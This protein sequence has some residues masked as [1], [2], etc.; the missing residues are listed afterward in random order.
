MARA[1][2]GGKLIADHFWYGPV[3]ETGLRRFAAEAVRHGIELRILPAARES[4]I[5]VDP[6]ARG[7]DA[8]RARTSVDA[9]SLL[10]L[11][12]LTLRAPLGSG[13]R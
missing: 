12:R 10:P 3:W 4:R 8:A 11:R 1:Y 7:L 2:I 13:I 5:Y 6:T 9:V